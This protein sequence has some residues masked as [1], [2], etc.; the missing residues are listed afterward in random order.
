MS[1]LRAL[2]GTRR[3]ELIVHPHHPPLVARQRNKPAVLDRKSVPAQQT[4]RISSEVALSQCRV[5]Q[6]GEAGH[7]PGRH[8]RQCDVSIEP[9][10]DVKYPRTGVPLEQTDDGLCLPCGHFVVAGDLA[11]LQVALAV[12]RRGPAGLYRRPVGG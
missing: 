1:S 12:P 8:V 11:S 6:N 7:G 2:P 5:L 9:R 10:P 3:V 4:A